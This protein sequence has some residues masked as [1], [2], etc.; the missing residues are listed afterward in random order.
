MVIHP[1]LYRHLKSKSRADSSS[2]YGVYMYKT[3]DFQ[4][5]TNVRK[6][7]IIEMIDYILFFSHFI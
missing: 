5:T 2:L 1:I 3:I 6:R 7:D 4:A